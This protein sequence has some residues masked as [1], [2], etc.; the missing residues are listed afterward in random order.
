MIKSLLI[1]P[2]AISRN[3]NLGN[4]LS[5]FGPFDYYISLWPQKDLPSILK[6][7]VILIIVRWNDKESRMFLRDTITMVNNIE[8]YPRIQLLFVFGLPKF[9]T[10]HEFAQIK[11]ENDL[12]QDMIIPSE[13]SFSLKNISQHKLS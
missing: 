4:S 12:Y 5:L 6:K 11:S 1:F 2:A 8:N 13:Y 10:Y 9:A 3:F 7:V